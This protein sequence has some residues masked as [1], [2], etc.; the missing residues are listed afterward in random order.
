MPVPTAWPPWRWRPWPCWPVGFQAVVR[1]EWIQWR[2]CGMNSLVQDVRFAFRSLRKNPGFTAVAVLTLALGIGAN[3]GI[4]SVIN[5]VLLRPLPYEEPDRL[6]ALFTQGRDAGSRFSLSYPDMLEIRG[7]ARDFSAVAPF[8]SKRYNFT[9][10]GEPH[11]VRAAMATDDLFR[12]LRAEALVGRT[13]AASELREQVVILGHGL[14]AGEFGS[15]RG[16][17]GRAISLDGRSFTVIGVMPSGFHFP[18]ED[19]Q[20]WVPLG[21]WFLSSPQ[22]ETDRHF[23]AFNAVARLA[24]GAT[25]EQALADLGV[26]AQ[27]INAA[28]RDQGEQRLE[29][30]MGSGSRGPGGAPRTSII[31]QTQVLVVPLLDNVLADKP[32]ALW[33]L[34]GAVGLVLLIACA[35]VA[36]LL[37]AR[38]TARRKEIAVRQAMGAGG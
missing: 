9:G 13:F 24:A 20:I 32:R 4:F 34:F 26:V 37:L 29:I 1:H 28:A 23:Y 38:G 30:S 6:V 36:A 12:V 15:D 17:I 7:L 11:E 8:T 19:T 27:R 22:A 31:P 10:G 16:V 33:I 3:T 2:P 21:E 14:W 18:D 35:N 5:A 25:S